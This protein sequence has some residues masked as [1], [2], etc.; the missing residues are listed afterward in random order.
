MYYTVHISKYALY[1]TYIQK[2]TFINIKN[3]IRYDTYKKT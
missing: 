3:N 1:P 2:A